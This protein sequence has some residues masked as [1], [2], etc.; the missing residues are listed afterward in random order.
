LL[1][2]PM[3]LFAICTSAQT[4]VTILDSLTSALLAGNS[5]LPA[6]Y[7][8]VDKNVQ[9]AGSS[10][11]FKVY[12][13]QRSSHLPYLN[14]VNVHADLLNSVGGVI[15]RL[16]LEST[17]LRLE[18]SF[19][20]SRE[21]PGGTYYLRT[22]TDDMVK[23]DP[24]SI[25]VTPIYVYNPGSPGSW[26]Q[27]QQCAAA[28]ATEKPPRKGIRFYPEGNHLINGI[29][30]L[31]AVEAF[32]VNGMPVM[33]EGI[34]RDSRDSI[35]ARFRADETGLGRFSINPIKGRKYRAV[36]GAQEVNLPDVPINAY[37]LALVK[38]D[39]HNLTFR[40]GLSDLLYSRSP[41][42]YVVGISKGRVCFTAAGKG[43]YLVN[44]PKE[45]FSEG[46]AEFYLFGDNRQLA[47]VRKL[48]IAKN[49]V[50]VQIE[51][52]KKQ[53][54]R[55]ATI[56]L[57]ISVTDS[58]GNPLMGLLSV[59]V[60]D[61]KA[62]PSMLSITFKEWLMKQSL[63]VSPLEQSPVST[64]REL[65]PL[66]YS[67]VVKTAPDQEQTSSGLRISGRLT[68]N[69]APVANQAVSVF[70][71]MQSSMIFYDTTDASGHFSVAPLRFYDSTQFLLHADAKVAE[72]KMTPV[73][74]SGLD[75]IFPPFV[76]ACS[77][78]SLVSRA[79]SAFE[80]SRADTFLIG[81][82]RGWLQQVQVK[83]SRRTQASGDSKRNSFSRIITREQ[84]SKYS[85]STTAN[86][87]KLVPGVIMVNNKITIRGGVPSLGG[88]DGLVEPLVIL[89]GVPA[90]TGGSVETFLNSIPPETIE[91]I[92]VLT[93]PEGAQYGSRGANGVIV[94]KTGQPSFKFNKT[95][96]VMYFYPKGYHYPL[97]FY[98]PD[99][100]VDAVREAAFNDNR[101]TIYWNGNLMTDDKGKL[102]V[103]FYSADPATKYTVTVT[104]LTS[105][106]EIIQKEITLSRE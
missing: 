14:S 76:I 92:E 50:R 9:P 33:S 86:A 80:K 51:P 94:I 42:S 36:V 74:D 11:W 106:G 31:V 83:G 6:I 100:S 102:M 48:Y 91:Y 75:S 12:L 71:E 18:G 88:N 22:Y 29:D 98:Q 73:Y 41:S 3:V 8:H 66:I 95:E 70:S 47:S 69:N 97:P 65:W 84:L 60:T 38:E 1:L 54:M 104:G 56:K 58:L 103:Q 35:V 44:V 49:D 19:A 89:D 90:S 17:D 32:D 23:A 4:P 93:G 39:A 82:T 96:N 37:Q 7:T 21:L 27:A 105:K 85:L 63:G 25:F 61:Q 101:S 87:V 34:V 99:Y 10:V 45:K 13:Y 52:D 81:N 72:W 64:S 26:A 79:L 55:R 67:G 78:D 24:S 59:S 68:K 46:I 57:N 53:Y 28:Y 30:N 20:L 2:L 77:K 5:R 62:A 16:L 43:M 15:D 40:I